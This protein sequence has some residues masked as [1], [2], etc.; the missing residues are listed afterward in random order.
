MK[1]IE[2]N[3]KKITLKRRAAYLAKEVKSH[4]DLIDGLEVLAFKIGME[5]Y[6]I[7]VAFIKKVFSLKDMSILPG[8]SSYIIGII[9]VRGDVVP[10]IDFKKIFGL[11]KA[12]NVTSQKV[13]V[14]ATEESIYGLLADDVLGLENI[15]EKDL[16]RDLP[17]LSG[18][19]L[20]YLKGVTQHQLII[21]DPLKI[22]THKA[23]V[24]NN[25][26]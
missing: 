25:Q 7:E 9:N 14:V 12:N 16:Q 19:R 2:D 6:G 13:I 15:S 20:E 1:P 10:V 5:R 8:V 18:V 23:I 11:R 17:T 26:T 22:A 21:F 3:D 4:S 24:V